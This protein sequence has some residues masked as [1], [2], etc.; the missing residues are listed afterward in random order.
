MLVMI[1]PP[2]VGHLGGRASCAE[3][4]TVLYFYKMKYK[5][6]EPKWLK[7]G[8]DLFLSKGHAAIA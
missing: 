4:L 7:T 2:K 8:I 6:K 1:K 5:P 3:I